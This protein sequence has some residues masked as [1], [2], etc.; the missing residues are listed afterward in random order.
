MFFYEIKITKSI[1]KISGERYDTSDENRSVCKFFIYNLN[2]MTRN[3][4]YN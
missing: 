1:H 3:S 4:I 2:I